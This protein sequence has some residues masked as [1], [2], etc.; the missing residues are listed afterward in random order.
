M[1]LGMVLFWC[2]VIV[3]IIWLIRGSSNASS[4]AWRDVPRETPLEILE[5]RFAEGAISADEYHERR[6][7]MTRSFNRHPGQPSEPAQH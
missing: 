6:E 3:G 4:N 1:M 5:R 7:A 2:A